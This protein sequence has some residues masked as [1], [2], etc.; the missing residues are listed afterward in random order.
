M[1][2]LGAVGLQL[3]PVVLPLFVLLVFSLLLLVLL[4]PV[5][6]CVDVSAPVHRVHHAIIVVLRM[7][8]VRLQFFRRWGA[9]CGYVGRGWS[10][11]LGEVAD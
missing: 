8:V 6:R 2:L 3:V 4:E 5:A 11:S 9:S 10:A 7:P 1:R